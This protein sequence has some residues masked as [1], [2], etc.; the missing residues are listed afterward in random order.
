MLAITGLSSSFSLRGEVDSG[1]HPDN[2]SQP[3]AHRADKSCVPNDFKI[4][5]DVGHTPEASGALSARGVPEYDF[6]LELAKRIENK[7]RE[8]G[9]TQTR[10]L[11]MR[12][13]GKTQLMQR[14]TLAN[15]FGADAFLSVH[16]DDVQPRY[17]KEWVYNGRNHH[18]SNK[19]SGYSLFVSYQNKFF[20]ESLEFARLLGKELSDRGLKFSDH[21]S[22][23]IPG[24]RR[25]ILDK[26][27][28]V[29]RFD[30][31]I[32]LKATKAPAV[33]L[34]AGVIVNQE[35]ETSLRSLERQDSISASVVEAV[36]QFCDKK[37]S[38]PRT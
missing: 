6:N 3:P 12:G 21:H 17:Y 23:N 8:N 29:Y 13:I 31:L 27:R 19:F 14:A 2:F 38:L 1:N 30:Q 26:E 35:E 10:L 4:M 7:L 16:H 28:G 36:N 24:E 34:E 5:V 33:L 11:K 32:V 9:Y 18:F 22:E 25:E 37:Q 20:R 15:S